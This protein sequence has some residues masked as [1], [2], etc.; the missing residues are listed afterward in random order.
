MGQL[1]HELGHAWAAHDDDPTTSSSDENLSMNAQNLIRYA[2]YNK[3][4]GYGKG[5]D[6]EIYPMPAYGYTGI[7]NSMYTWI[8]DTISHLHPDISWETYW[9]PGGWPDNPAWVYPDINYTP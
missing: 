3:I 5:G 4:P 8:P 2:L 7:P 6:L 9:G 1:A